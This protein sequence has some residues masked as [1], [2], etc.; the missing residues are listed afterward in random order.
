M[1]HNKEWH[2]ADG[3]HRLGMVG[4]CQDGL[5]GREARRATI[6]ELGSWLGV[7]HWE[8]GIRSEFSRDSATDLLRLWASLFTFS[9]YGALSL[10]WVGLH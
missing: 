3:Q 7:G 5:I 4:G 10:E 6:S 1:V 8:R 9:A 2:A